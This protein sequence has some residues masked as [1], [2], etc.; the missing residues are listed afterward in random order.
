MNDT[1]LQTNARLIRYSREEGIDA[2]LMFNGTKVDALLAPS[3][4]SNSS[5]MLLSLKPCQLDHQL[6]LL[7]L[8]VTR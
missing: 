6:L 4:V 2:A 7:L 1:Y 8:Q 5:C 3:G